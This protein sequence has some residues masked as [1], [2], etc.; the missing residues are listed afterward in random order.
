MG[1]VRVS[2]WRCWGAGMWCGVVRVRGSEHGLMG[3]EVLTIELGVV[4]VVVVEY[5]AR[6]GLIWDW[7]LV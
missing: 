1:I 7:G 3:L 6:C 4:V 2:I 5:F